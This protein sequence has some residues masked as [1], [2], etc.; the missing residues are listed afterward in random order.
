VREQEE[1]ALAVQVEVAARPVPLPERAAGRLDLDDVGAE[2]GEELDAGR[3][4][5]EL[6]E[7]EDAD[8][9]EDRGGRSAT[10]RRP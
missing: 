4:E 9:R 10:T 5:E 3:P 2:V 6:R 1:R 8:A 7:A